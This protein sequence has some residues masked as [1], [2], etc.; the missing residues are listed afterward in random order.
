[1][2]VCVCTY[3]NATVSIV[4]QHCEASQ[5]FRLA[6]FVDVNFSL[7]FCDAPASAT[8]IIDF[9]NSQVNLI[10]KKLAARQLRLLSASSHHVCSMSVVHTHKIQIVV[11]ADK[12]H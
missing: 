8:T 4:L 5:P 11:A 9:D 3:G 12:L 6:D 1:M 2:Y 10:V 7:N